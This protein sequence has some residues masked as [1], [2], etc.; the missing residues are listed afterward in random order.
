M[1]KILNEFEFTS[2]EQYIS[3]KFNSDKDNSFSEEF[4]K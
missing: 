1:S 4:Q 2:F 3:K